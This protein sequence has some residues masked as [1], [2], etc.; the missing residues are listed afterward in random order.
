[1]RD[2]DY[3][4][5]PFCIRI[6]YKHSPTITKST[7]N[8]IISISRVIYIY[9]ACIELLSN[10]VESS[11]VNRILKYDQFIEKRLQGILK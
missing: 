6:N 5:L 2:L 9:I 3:Y 11:I 8:I 7:N 4:L 1:M 10:D